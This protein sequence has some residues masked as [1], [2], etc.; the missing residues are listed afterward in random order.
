[1]HLRAV[2]PVGVLVSAISA[3]CGPSGPAI[4]EVEGT[5]MLDG[6]PLPMASVVFIPENGRPAGAIT[7]ENGHYVL[8][9]TEGRQGAI[10]GKN[11][12]IITTKRDPGKDADGNML[13]ASPETVPM[14]YNAQTELTFVV[15]DGKR[16]IADFKL[17]SEGPI[18]EASEEL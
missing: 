18:A 6:K 4:A 5:V 3:G 7:D 11:K 10:P 15:E 8:N 14:K 9:F 13:P 2:I 17:D 12:V 1:M 16:N